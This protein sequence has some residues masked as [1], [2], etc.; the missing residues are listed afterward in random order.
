MM[1]P[2]THLLR[3]T[4]PFA[5]YDHAGSSLWRS[6]PEG[7]VVTDAADIALLTER[8]APVEK[9]KTEDAHDD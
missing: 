3:L 8:G 5:F 2:K 6:W 4:A 7:A 1:K 9:I